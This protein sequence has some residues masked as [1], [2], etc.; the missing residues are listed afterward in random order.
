MLS[1][2]NEAQDRQ[3]NWLYNY[4]LL[5]EFI[6][7]FSE[8]KLTVTS[9]CLYY[10]TEVNTTWTGDNWHEMSKTVFWKNKKNIAECYLLNYFL[11]SML[12]VK[13]NLTV[14][15]NKNKPCHENMYFLGICGQQRDISAYTFHSLIWVICVHPHS[16]ISALAVR[17]QKHWI[18]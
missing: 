18:L 11:P 7:L 10:Q 12:R 17:V 16:P 6:V 14:W 2:Y 8:D 3:E 1:M 13:I 5:K 15:Y 4:L 9:D